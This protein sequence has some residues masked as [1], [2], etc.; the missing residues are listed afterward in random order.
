MR[1]SK[2]KVAS[3]LPSYNMADKPIH[4]RFYHPDIDNFS[5]G[6]LRKL[7]REFSKLAR[8]LLLD[9]VEMLLREMGLN[10]RQYQ[11]INDVVQREFTGGTNF[12]VDEIEKGSFKLGGALTFVAL[13]IL[14]GTLWRSIE[15]A[16][17]R[18]DLSLEI[19]EQALDAFNKVAKHLKNRKSKVRKLA[20]RYKDRILANSFKVDDVT[21]EEE[22]E[23]TVI[24]FDIS[25][26]DQRV[27]QIEELLEK[28]EL[29][30]SVNNDIK[31]L[32]KIMRNKRN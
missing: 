19:E 9:E 30:E 32:K 5:D 22:A 28:E 8:Q 12:M 7:I 29:Q 3:V 26:I 20:P 1:D 10:Y 25:S 24:N 11:S 6:T 18:S 31:N 16:Y 17:D 4:I 21:I 15:K 27:M 14:K 2:S 13:G 23:K